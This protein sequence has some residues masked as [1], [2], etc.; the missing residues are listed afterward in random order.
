MKICKKIHT[1]YESLHFSQSV[2]PCNSITSLELFLRA[3]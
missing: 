2:V 1:G 3:V